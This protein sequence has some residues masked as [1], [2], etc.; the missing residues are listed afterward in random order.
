[1]ASEVLGSTLDIHSGGEDLKFPQ[2]SIYFKVLNEVA[3]STAVSSF[4]TFLCLKMNGLKVWH[5]H[6]LITKCS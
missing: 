2:A 4:R 3:N 1:M 5:A 6:V